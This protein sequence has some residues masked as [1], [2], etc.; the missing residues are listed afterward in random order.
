MD[1]HLNYFEVRWKNFKSFVDTDWIKIKPITILIGTNNS[2]KTNFITP[3]SLMNQTLYSKDTDSPLIIKGHNYDGGN[4]QEIV[5]NYDKRK[6]I[7]FGYRYHIHKTDKKIKSVGNY[8]PGSIEITL[9]LKKD[10]T[11]DLIIKKE[12]IYD[13]YLREYFSF[14]LNSKNKYDYNGVG[15][16]DL[17]PFETKAINN[18]TPL[19]FLF[20]PNSLFFELSRIK[21]NEDIK[22]K[23][24]TERFSHGLTELIN[25]LTYNYVVI[26]D[27]I[28][29]LSYIG[30]IREL[31][32]RM[33]EITNENFNT[34]GVRGENMGNLI[35]KHFSKSNQ[36]LNEWINKFEFGGIL[37]INPISLHYNLYSIQFDEKNSKL[38]TKISNAGFGVSQVLPFIIQA[39]VSPKDSITI[40]EQP[41]IHL[42]PRLQCLLA[43]LFVFMAKRK[44]TIILE[45]HSEHLLLRLRLLIA[46]K[47]IS[48]N[49]VAI[50]F[51][52]KKDGIS[53]I[54]EINLQ[55]N[56]HIKPID[57]PDGFFGETL[58]T[59]FALASEQSKSKKNG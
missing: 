22:V 29:D 28:G 9:G 16:Q 14:V 12:S 31:P 4:Y 43:D 13:V 24:K 59:S 42:N 49:D 26:K 25:A 30:P 56:G 37:K 23:R 50:Y 34:I 36:K 53:N 17:S 32:H 20:T 57:W 19:N 35:K 3:F 48:A 2:G 5:N 46:E 1:K 15:I 45:T 41:E 6:N 55:D 21:T 40:A 7:F 47:K 38:Y 58:K 8:P 18:S 54:K 11:T 10:S 33:Y 52:D 39:L 44:Q 51:I 27:K